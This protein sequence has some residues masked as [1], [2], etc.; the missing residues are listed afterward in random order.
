MGWIR[1]CRR[2]AAPGLG[3]VVLAITATLPASGASL[4]TL[5]PSLGELRN[6][7]HA[8][9]NDSGA[10]DENEVLARAAQESIIRTAPGVS[11]P[12]QAYLA[13]AAQAAHVPTVGG[14]W[15]EVTNRPFLNDPIPGYN[16][17]SGYSDFGS[18]Y[19]LV[20]GRMTALASSGR[21]V[22]A[23]A[24]DGGV[25]KSTDRGGHWTAWSQGLPRLSIGALATDPADGSV[26]VGLGEANTAFENFNAFGVY[27][28]APGAH[29]WHRVGGSE[30]TS[31]NIYF[32]RF[33]GAGHV[34]AATNSGLFRHGD[35]AAGPWHLVLKP[36]PNPA[37]SPYRTSQITDVTFQPG[38]RGR[39]VLAALGWRGGTLTGDVAYNG[40]YVSHA[41]GA[42]GTFHRI[43]PKGAI[44]PTDIGRTTF[45]A[46]GGRIYAVIESPSH[47]ASPSPSNGFTALLGVFVSRSG[48]PAGP[49]TQVADAV[50]LANSGSAITVFG[51]DPGVQAWYN[52][53]LTVDPH[54]ANHVYLGLEEVFETTNGGTTWKAIGPYAGYGLPCFHGGATDC[55]PTT[56]P[57][58]HAVMVDG[59]TLYIGSDGGVW[60]RPVDDHAQT[61]WV[62]L[63]ATLRTTQ[64]YSAG[65]GRMG[66]GDAVW[67]GL[68]DNGAT[69]V[70]PGAPRVIQGFTGDGGDVI[71]DPA[72]AARVVN[73]YTDLDMAL[74]TNAGRTY[75]EMTPACGAFGYT[76]NPCDPAPR[77]I[78]PFTADVRNPNHW[79]AGGEFVWD[80]HAAWNTTCSATA[81]DWKPVHDTGGS[82]T[83]LAV[84]GGTIY[85]AWCGDGCNPNSGVPFTSGIDTNA[86]GS[87]HTVHAPN[88]PNRY[89]TGLA[90]DP[91]NARHVLAVFGGFSRK[92]IPAGSTGHVF[93]SWNGGTTWTNI[94]GNL[95]DNPADDVVLAHHR[96]IVA[97]DLGVYI[98]RDGTHSWSRLGHGLPNAATWALALSPDH[99]YVVAATHGR[100]QWRIAL[101]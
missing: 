5:R 26:W 84:N 70:R 74:S 45:A 56:H 32:L 86:G 31:R 57:D 93:E 10:S 80:D 98:A 34:Y 43:T 21:A 12:A 17:P 2:A 18:G 13:A 33:D 87:W 68:Q 11:V 66:H 1:S 14:S 101:R 47:L 22:Y 92:W 8:T 75:R 77:F 58:Q 52:E 78:A 42:A 61:G 38:T 50:K 9:A 35:G 48:N 62:D 64:Y 73:E 24:A 89:I 7:P 88:L 25:W 53:F 69:L 6:A 49:W 82:T 76:P 28:L 27:R 16:D 91:G 59:G 54:N 46:G 51:E 90:V 44:D 67:G 40:F 95:P 100:G 37:H 41:G 23:G 96:L 20:T 99:S 65:I 85:A 30:L 15:R 79:V 94:T 3:A 36:D 29:V 83:A 63:N 19:G 72:N 39:V 81:C 71:V 55:P 4:H 60:R 97:T